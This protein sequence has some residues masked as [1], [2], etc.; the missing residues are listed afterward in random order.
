M[1]EKPQL[2]WTGLSNGYC[3]TPQ[4]RPEAAVQECRL[5]RGDNGLCFPLILIGAMNFQEISDV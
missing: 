4:E 1:L 5:V 3:F 2:G